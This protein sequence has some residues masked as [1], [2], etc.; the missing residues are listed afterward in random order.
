MHPE[1]TANISKYFHP[2]HLQL[3]YDELKTSQR[4]DSIPGTFYTDI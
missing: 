1:L 4:Q 2:A 3:K